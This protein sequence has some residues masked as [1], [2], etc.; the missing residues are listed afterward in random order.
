MSLTFNASEAL[1]LANELYKATDVQC[2]SVAVEVKECTEWKRAKRSYQ[3]DLAM[4]EVTTIVIQFKR[5]L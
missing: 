3:S 4:L 5:E 2:S 1:T